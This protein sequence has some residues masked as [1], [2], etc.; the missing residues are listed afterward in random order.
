MEL[1][2]R[3][4]NDLV[5][6]DLQDARF[7]YPKTLVVKSTFLNLL[8]E[9]HRYFAFNLSQVEMLDSFGLAVIV[10]LL[11]LCKSRKGELVLFG[12]H[13][14][15]LKLFEVTQVERVVKNFVHEAQA[16]EHLTRCQAEQP[17][18]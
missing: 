18:Q 2:Y 11:K 1:G 16:L 4:V 5:I 10:S 13:E 9:G 17:A 15:V 6:M 8:Q 3:I 14:A 12:S 7:F